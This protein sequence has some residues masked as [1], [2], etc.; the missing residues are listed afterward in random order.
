MMDGD[1]IDRFAAQLGRRWSAIAP[2]LASTHAMRCALQSEWRKLEP[3]TAGDVYVRMVEEQQQIDPSAFVLVFDDAHADEDMK[4]RAVGAAMAVF[5]QAG[6]TP[7]AGARGWFDRDRWD[8][9]G[10]AEE[11]RPSDFELQAALVWDQATMAA[12]SASRI[13]LLRGHESDLGALELRWR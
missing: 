10:F 11:A 2:S 5:G 8:D 1:W 6:V 9:M 3:E 4:T 7:A 13:E 12:V